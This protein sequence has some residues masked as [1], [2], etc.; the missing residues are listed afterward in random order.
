MNTPLYTFWESVS[1]GII[2]SL[3]AGFLTIIIIE[4]FKYYKINLQHKKF[5]KVFGTYDRDS[6]NLVLPALQVRPD[7]IN[8]LQNSNLQGNQFPLLKYGGALIKSSKLLG[9]ADIV[10]LKYVLNIITANLGSKSVVMTDE[11]LQNHLD[12]SFVSFGGSSFYCTYVIN[13][14]NNRF[15]T[16]NGNTIVRKLDPNIFFQID[17]TYDYGFIIKYRHENFPNKTWIIIAGLGESG[18][19]GAGWFLSTHWKQL[20]KDF[21]GNTFGL[22]VRV[23]HGIDNS[24]IEVDR[25]N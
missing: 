16:F 19:R 4:G 21:N 2:G 11:D 7:V 12:I 13:Q 10:S 8:L 22:V 24:A 20:S 6:L 1:S 23:N 3:I 5:I 15:Y 18:T 25:I 9:Y 14:A 17:P